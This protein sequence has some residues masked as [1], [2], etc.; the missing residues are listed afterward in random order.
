MKVRHQLARWRMPLLVETR[1]GRLRDHVD[2]CIS[3]QA[4]ESR[5]RTVQR[6]LA[7]LAGERYESPYDLVPGVLAGLDL[8]LTAAKRQL[9]RAAAAAVAGAV[10]GAVVIARLARRRVA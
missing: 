8:P 9:G 2:S 3:C 10:A 6:T 4:T 1:T 7:S 5:Y